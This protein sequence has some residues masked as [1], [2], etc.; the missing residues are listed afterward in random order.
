MKSNIDCK[1]DITYKR[2]TRMKMAGILLIYILGIYFLLTKMV[3]LE[4]EAVAVRDG[5]EQLILDMVA[6]FKKVH[7]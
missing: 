5:V 3:Q 1:S 2:R 6:L 4:D 7:A